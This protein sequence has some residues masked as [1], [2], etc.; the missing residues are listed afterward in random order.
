MTRRTI[1]RLAGIAPVALSLL[2]FGLVMIVVTTGWERHLTDEGA[3]AHLFQLMIAAEVP[4]FLLFLW[5]ADWR[6]ARTLRG[7]IF[8]QAAALALAFG[9]VAFFRL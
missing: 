9:A 2:A 3:A 7:L 5:T 8:C 4:L 1:N 6:Q